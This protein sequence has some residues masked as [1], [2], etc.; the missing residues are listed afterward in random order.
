LGCWYLAGEYTYHNASTPPDEPSV[1]S[2]ISGSVSV[3][4]TGLWTLG[5][6]GNFPG[7]L[8]N[9]YTTVTSPTTTTAAPDSSV[10]AYFVATNAAYGGKYCEDGTFDDGMGNVKPKYRKADTSFY[11]Y[12]MDTNWRINDVG[13]LGNGG[14]NV[15][16]AVNGAST[17]PVG[18]IWQDMDRGQDLFVSNDFYST[19]ATPTLSNT[20]VNYGGNTSNG[21][22][23]YYGSD[24]TLEY[25]PAAP[26]GPWVIYDTQYILL[27]QN[28]STSNTPPLSG[29]TV[30]F[31]SE[32][33]PTLIGPTCDGTTTTTTTPE[34][35]TTTTT[36]TAAPGV[37]GFIVS[38][39]GDANYNGTY[40]PGG[41]ANGGPY[42]QKTDA[43]GTYYIMYY[44]FNGFWFIQSLSNGGLDAEAPDYYHAGT[45]EAGPR[46]DS[47]WDGA[48]MTSG[49]PPTLT[50]ATC[51][52]AT[53]T[54][55]AA[56]AGAFTLSG[57]G[58][59]EVNGC[60]SEVGIHNGMPYYSNGIY[61]VW[62][63]GFEWEWF[64]TQTVGAGPAVYI[65][66]D[67]NNVPS[68]WSQAFGPF[69]APILLQGC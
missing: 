33:V 67:Q 24:S 60:Y 10:P 19:S 4:P 50:S 51:V 40:C 54:T 29:W 15:Y 26:A 21:K 42:W 47:I 22:P 31:G 68:S 17:P 8:D 2:S 11:I 27:Y 23:V 39:A 41:T 45:I 12:Y 43:N 37:E 64:I 38:G 35:T 14:S 61:F 5:C 52:G 6:P 49:P 28:I 1:L 3:L 57:A 65:G 46:I 34:P 20:Y 32:P 9:F 69:P 36:T 18:L 44:K 25:E 16:G 66:S 59:G 58:A 53:T 56:P 55:T 62:Y 63:E 7:F 13:N 48:E 30:Y